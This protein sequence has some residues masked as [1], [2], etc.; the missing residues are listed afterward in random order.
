MKFNDCKINSYGILTAL[1]LKLMLNVEPTSIYEIPIHF[2][3]RNE[4]GY[5]F[6]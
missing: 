2:Y 4:L 1:Q 6:T 5:G 3:S